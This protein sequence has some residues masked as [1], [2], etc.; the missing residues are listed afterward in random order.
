MSE[1]PPTYRAERGARL[2]GVSRRVRLALGLGAQRLDTHRVLRGALRVQVNRRALPP[3][4]FLPRHREQHPPAQFTNHSSW[5]GKHTHTFGIGKA[6]HLCKFDSSSLFSH[7]E[8]RGDNL[9]NIFPSFLAPWPLKVWRGPSLVWRESPHKDTAHFR[10][11]RNWTFTQR[12][13][14]YLKLRIIT[15]I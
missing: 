1:A 8:S 3:R 13:Y 15:E 6:P 12:S 5:S 2:V 14:L 10:R 7:S 4:R 11:L 9:D